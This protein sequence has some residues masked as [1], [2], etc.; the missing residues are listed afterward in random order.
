MVYCMEGI[1][2]MLKNDLEYKLIANQLVDLRKCKL[3]TEEKAHL[4]KRFKEINKLGHNKVA[5]A[6]NR[7]KT[8]VHDTLM[9]AEAEPDLLELTIE[10]GKTKIHNALRKGIRTKSDYLAQDVNLLNEDLIRCKRILQ[11]HILKPKGDRDS[12]DLVIELE[13]FIRQIKGK[14]NQKRIR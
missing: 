14:L 3:S 1:S 4:I 2:H 7:S 11:I 9:Y 8:W 6:L 10:E 13:T 12:L 5:K